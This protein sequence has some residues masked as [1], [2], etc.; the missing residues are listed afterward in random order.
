MAKYNFV[1][2]TINDMLSISVLAI[3]RSLIVLQLSISLSLLD[4]TTNTEEKKS[5]QN[6]KKETGRWVNGTRSHSLLIFFLDYLL[7]EQL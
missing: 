3:M 6:N 1:C 4:E 2:L 5:A 7:T